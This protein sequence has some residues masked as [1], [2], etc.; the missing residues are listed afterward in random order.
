MKT[1]Q[2]DSLRNNLDRNKEVYQLGVILSVL[3]D[4]NNFIH[5]IIQKLEKDIEDPSQVDSL[6]FNDYNNG[7]NGDKKILATMLIP[8]TNLIN[9]KYENLESFVGMQVKVRL[10]EGIARDAVVLPEPF[11]SF[12]QQK[13]IKKVLQEYETKDVL[14][15]KFE[16]EI[17][18][19]L[20]L[21][22]NDLG[23]LDLKGNDEF[24]KVIVQNNH[25]TTDQIVQNDNLKKE[26]R[27]VIDKDISLIPGNNLLKKVKTALCHTPAKFLTGK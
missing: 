21:S 11:L 12:S 20:G 3:Q 8:I 22:L 26:D 9:S 4:K 25:A 17:N 27:L 14:D 5:A 10:V 6:I 24:V 16:E 18:E 19:L 1:N 13:T 7:P 23:Y 2:I 15:K